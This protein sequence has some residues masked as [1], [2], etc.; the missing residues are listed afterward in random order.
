[1]ATDPRQKE[2]WLREFRLNGFLILRGFLPVELVE[3]MYLELEP[4]L[5]A[6][7]LKWQRGES[8]SARGPARFAFDVTRY[9]ELM[10]GGALADDRFRRN[11]VIEDLVTEI[12][13]PASWARGWTQVECVWPGSEHMDW[14]SDQTIEDTRNPDDPNRTV[15]VTYNIPLVDFTW[16]NGPMELLPGSHVQPRSFHSASF[17][18]VPNLYPVSLRL[19]RG[20]VVLRDGNTLHRG[21]PN[22][23]EQP[24]PMLD[25][26]YKAGGGESPRVASTGSAAGPETGP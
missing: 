1:M 4:I 24:R 6:E 26:T 7:Y 15:R 22:L 12:L 18:E 5:R 10:R 19:G 9:A 20:D 17:R 25:Q 3:R 21:T 11:P 13:R 2:L 8:K 16:A 14:H 23:H